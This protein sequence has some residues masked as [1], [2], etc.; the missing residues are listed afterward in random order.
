MQRPVKYSI[1]KGMGGKNGA[2]QF[3]LI[4]FDGTRERDGKASPEGAILIEGAPTSGKNTYD[5]SKKVSFA[6]SPDDIGKFISMIKT[7]GEI[8][9]V[10]NEKNKK[11]N[12]RVGN[13]DKEG[14]PT[15]MFSLNEGAGETTKNIVLPISVH[16]MVVLRNLLEA[17]IPAILGWTTCTKSDSQPTVS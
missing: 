9:H 4:P 16:E 1:Y 11:L 5:W 7:G 10:Y 6:L 8:F 15:W 13:D 12:L 14:N 2:I 17:A 3:S